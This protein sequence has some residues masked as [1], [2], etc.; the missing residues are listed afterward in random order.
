MNDECGRMKFCHL[1]ENAHRGVSPKSDD[2]TAQFA[3][4]KFIVVFGGD[5]QRTEGVKPQAPLPSPPR[6]RSPDLLK[7]NLF[8]ETRLCHQPTSPL[9]IWEGRGDR[10]SPLPPFPPPLVFA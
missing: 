4:Q 9:P 10:S 8:L 1:Q 2:S 6:G 5:V 3:T 7:Q